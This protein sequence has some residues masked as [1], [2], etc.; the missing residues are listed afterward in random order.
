[1]MTSL[2][3]PRSGPR[4]FAVV[5]LLS[6]SMAWLVGC[7]TSDLVLRVDLLSF[8]PELQAPF[9]FSPVPATP[10]GL[11][12]G[13]QA[14]VADQDVNLVEGLG[15][16]V[17]FKDASLRLRTVANGATG[18]GTDTVR[19]YLSDAGTLPTTTPPVLTQILTFTAGV[20]D[21]VTSE[22]SQDGRLTALFAQKQLRIAVTTSFRGP[23]TGPSLTGNLTVTA[24]DVVVVARRKLD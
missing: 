15:D 2:R 3:A 18:S 13:E 21:T 23:S 14:L 4:A 1:M 5:G 16:A 24:F 8:T 6:L 11:A 7:G 17:T 20:P 9:T 10:G 19:V 22:T 12:T